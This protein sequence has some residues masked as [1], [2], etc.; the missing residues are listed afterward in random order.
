MCVRNAHTFLRHSLTLPLLALTVWPGTGAGNAQR[1]SL[2]RALERY[3]AD[4]H[5]YID[6]MQVRPCRSS[7]LSLLLLLFRSLSP[8]LLWFLTALSLRLILSR[9]L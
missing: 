4:P 7:P 9:T 1:L 5:D 8:R 2:L 6:V 3:R